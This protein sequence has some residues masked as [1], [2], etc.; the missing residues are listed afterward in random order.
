MATQV[1]ETEA[2][3]ISSNATADPIMAEIERAVSADVSALGD[4]WNRL[5]NGESYDDIA[6]ARG[7]TTSS[8]VS[9]RMGTSSSVRPTKNE[10]SGMTTSSS[11]RIWSLARSI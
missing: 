3:E 5:K 4:V 9:D 6:L 8:F 2:C 11:R 7:T 1:A 10:L